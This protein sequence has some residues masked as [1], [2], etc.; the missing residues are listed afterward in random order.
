MV[1][2]IITM[3]AVKEIAKANAKA[4][5]EDAA[6]PS[7]RVVGKALA[8]C[9]SLFATPI[10]RTAEIFEN[11]LHKYID[12]LEGIQEA[13]LVA[14][15]TRIL[16]PI[17]EKLRY[18]DDEVVSDYYAQIL[19]TASIKN[20][21]NKVMVTFIEIL[22]RLSADELKIIEYVNSKE[23]YA[24]VEGLTSEELV[25]Y[26]LHEDVK[27]VSITGGFPVLNINI[28]KKD[29]P[30]YNT[31]R[32]NFS[33]IPE[34]MKLIAPE[35]IDMYLDNMMSLGLLKKEQ[36]K[37]YAFTKIYE[38]LEKNSYIKKV[39][40]KIGEDRRLEIERGRIDI[41]NLGLKLLSLGGKN[42]K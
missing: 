32:K 12:K 29:D 7:V 30:A 26:G 24:Q 11:N 5:Y 31:L 25:K 18:T 34:L 36:D 42:E 10:G 6:Q 17:L 38:F 27:K 23:N 2:E 19:A 28:R 9:T 3:D 35:N 21:S 40:S 16:V 4:M 13:E 14:P 37:R 41:T 8:Q 33:L 15:D 20:Q 39:E 1:P 22:N